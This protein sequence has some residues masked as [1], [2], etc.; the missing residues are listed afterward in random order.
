MTV[1]AYNQCIA[2]RR[3]PR[4]WHRERLAGPALA[5][6]YAR[7]C[8]LALGGR[9][10]LAVVPDLTPGSCDPRINMWLGAA[11]AFRGQKQFVVAATTPHKSL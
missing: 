6:V 10:P 8:V 2:M 3:L 1:V 7:S 4:N 11:V 5:M 9:S